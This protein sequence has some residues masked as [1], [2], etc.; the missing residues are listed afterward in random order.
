MKRIKLTD[1][2]L[3]QEQWIESCGGTL[4]GYVARYGAADDPGRY[5]NGGEAIYEADVAYLEELKSKT[6]DKRRKYL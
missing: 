2:I 5:G 6:K 4:A 3:D 1:A